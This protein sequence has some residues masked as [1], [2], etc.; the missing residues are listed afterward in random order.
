MGTKQVWLPFS[1]ETVFLSDDDA[2]LNTS[3]KL[4]N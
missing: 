4:G 1:M 3:G 2:R